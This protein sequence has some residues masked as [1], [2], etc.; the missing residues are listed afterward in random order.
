M[1]KKTV[2]SHD[3]EIVTSAKAYTSLSGST[4][5]LAKTYKEEELAEFNHLTLFCER[6]GITLTSS[7]AEKGD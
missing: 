3:H 5:F 1:D 2:Q 6:N 7:L 4:G